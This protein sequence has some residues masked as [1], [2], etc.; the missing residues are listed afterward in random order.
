MVPRRMAL[1]VFQVPPDGLFR[2]NPPSLQT[3]SF[4]ARCSA[5]WWVSAR[6]L[7]HTNSLS[8]SESPVGY[9]FRKLLVFS[10]YKGLADRESFVAQYLA[11]ALFTIG[12]ASSLGMDDL[13]AAFAAGTREP[14]LS[15]T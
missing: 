15:T 4:W 3:K 6:A 14:P 7:E 5:L 8:V 12:V 1:Q 13:L 11:L 2:A 9:G 10:H